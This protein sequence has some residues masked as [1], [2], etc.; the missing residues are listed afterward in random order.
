MRSPRML[1][2][3]LSSTDHL[4]GVDRCVDCRHDI[5]WNHR[6]AKQHHRP[7]LCTFR[8]SLIHNGTMPPNTICRDS[9]KAPE[10]M[11]CVE[12]TDQLWLSVAPVGQAWL[13]IS[14]EKSVQGEVAPPSPPPYNM[15]LQPRST[16]KTM[17]TRGSWHGC[18]HRPIGGT[19]SEVSPRARMGGRQAPD[20]RKT[21]QEVNDA[22]IHHRGQLWPISRANL[23]LAPTRRDSP[24][25]QST[26]S[27]CPLAPANRG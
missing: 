27:P 2:S 13:D 26:F 11:S 20:P 9:L 21:P 15:T 5:Q 19:V 17:P 22:H 10:D 8:S 23:H 4:E 1:P 24:V 12:P 18:H 7:H 16:S 14:V 6:S 25:N 3:P